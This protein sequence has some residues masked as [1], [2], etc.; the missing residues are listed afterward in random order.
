MSQIQAQA[1]IQINSKTY[2]AII[3]DDTTKP[4]AVIHVGPHKTGSTSIQQFITREK[5][6][7]RKDNY[8]VP[9]VPG[10][11]HSK[12][13]GHIAACFHETRSEEAS[14]LCPHKKK[15]LIIQTFAKFI[16]ETAALNENITAIP[17]NILISSE[18]FDRPQM[19]IAT[20]KNMFEPRFKVRIVIYYRR[21]YDW[22]VSYHNQLTKSTKISVPPFVEW[23]TID[24]M[25]Q[26]S[27]QHALQVYKR[28]SS[29]FP[30]ESAVEV[31]IIER[32]MSNNISLEESFFCEG[33]PNTKRV[34]NQI[35]RNPIM[36][37]KNTSVLLGKSE[38]MDAI[39]KR[40]P[41]ITETNT[42]L[43]SIIDERWNHLLLNEEKYVNNN[44]DDSKMTGDDSNAVEIIPWVCLPQVIQD[45]LLYMSQRFEEEINNI[46]LYTSSY[47]Y[48]NNNG[49]KDHC[50]ADN[51]SINELILEQDFRKKNVGS[52]KTFCSVNTERILD[53]WDEEEWFRALLKG[54]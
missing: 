44:N 35:R 33:V 52:S 39:R 50:Y 16:D 13:S 12:N 4:F 32:L 36:K 17:T 9:V 54:D 3:D 48:N 45:K 37:V 38:L 8:V 34:C 24:Q 6:L 46:T 53:S 19:D 15:A 5:E 43:K 23:L 7:I 18:E 30:S 2:T 27:Q 20:L 42:N 41:N 49:N 21:F 14:S 29:Y 51:C 26:V 10:G 31:I 11:W 25:D 28:Y 47:Y 40:Y 1:Q 22:V